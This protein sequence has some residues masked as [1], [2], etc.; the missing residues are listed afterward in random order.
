MSLSKA[1]F[2]SILYSRTRILLHRFLYLLL[3]STLAVSMTTSVFLTNVA[4]IALISLWALELDFRYKWKAFRNAPLLHLFLVLLAVHLLWLTISDNMAAGLDDIRQKLPLFAI[5]IVVLTSRPLARRHLL[6][7]AFLYLTTVVVVSFVGLG[8]YIAIDDLPYRKIIPTISHVRF[9]LHVCFAVCL[10]VFLTLRLRL[11]LT[12]RLRRTLFVAATLVI[13]WLLVFL[14]LIQSYTA[15]VILVILSLCTLFFIL[16][17]HTDKHLLMIA[18]GG[19][20]ALLVSFIVVVSAAVNDYYG[21]YDAHGPMVESG[22]L[23]YANVDEASIA[24]GWHSLTGGDMADTTANGYSVESTLI[25]Y[26][27]A[28]G[29]TKDSAGVC[30][31]SDVDIA[32]VGRGVANP[33]YLHHFSLRTMTYRMLFEYETA[34]CGGSI[35]DFSMLERIELWRSALHL[36]QNHPWIG[37]GTGDAVEDF[38]QQLE[39]DQSVLVGTPKDMH[40]QYLYFLVAFGLVGSLLLLFFFIRALVLTPSLHTPLSVAYLI[41]LLV[42]F[43][44]EVTLATLA[45]C[46]FASLPLTLVSQMPPR[47][48]KPVRTAVVPFLRSLLVF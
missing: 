9:S 1:S 16:R 3:L 35:R 47:S 48:S 27:N 24:A 33:A 32:A 22:G 29:L 6:W 21:S 18:F 39:A 13:A 41:I 28:K 10:I 43:V 42:S 19:L 31:L 5:P 2:D 7:L 23:I 12:L 37:V 15:F 34:R 17:T 14:L 36:F 8:R 20:V 26:L 25:R 30:A 46:L 40:S 38:H 45:G 11:H 44:S 4:W